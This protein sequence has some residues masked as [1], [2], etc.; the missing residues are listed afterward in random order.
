MK[1][2]IPLALLGF[3]NVGQAFTQ[4][5]QSKRSDVEQEYGI[6]WKVVGISTKTHGN[7]IDMRGLNVDDAEGLIA[8]GKNLSKL[9]SISPP[10]DSLEFISQ[11]GAEVLFETTPVNYET[12]QP[13]V[14]YIRRG[15]QLNMH[16][17]TAN[18]GPVVHAYYELSKLAE[19]KKRKFYFEST[20][21][22]GTPI[23]SLWRDTL[24]GANITSFHGVL[25]STTNLIL[26]LMEG[27]NSFE[28]ALS[29]AQAI[30]I[31]ETNPSGD[32]DGW[33]AAVKVAALATVL[34][35]IPIK[36]VDIKREGIKGISE[37]MVMLS[38][39]SGKRWKLICE[40]EQFDGHVQAAVYPKEIGSSD[41]LF[42]VMG[43]SS[44]ITFNSDVLGALTIV[45]EN[46]GTE[47]TAYGL[48]ADFINAV[49]RSP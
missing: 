18:K 25:N 33:D 28:D 8:E 30:G 1:E 17:I 7:A 27:G 24:P 32:I 42:G 15:L 3:G 4:L 39:N 48:M 26:T 45:E 40:A 13:A 47:T 23:F 21:M 41:P 19:A 38:K 10:A 44:S 49:K 9:S 22:D 37:D 31:T 43:T 6:S 11:C 5:L 29:H 34:M 14:D 16:V 46:P 35:N 2:K 36:P 20:V 12:G